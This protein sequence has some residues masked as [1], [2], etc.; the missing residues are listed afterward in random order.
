[1]VDETMCGLD[2]ADQHDVSVRMLSGGQ[3]KRACI[4]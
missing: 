2:L 4:P 3:R 1:M